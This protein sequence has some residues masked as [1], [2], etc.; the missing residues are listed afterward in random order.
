MRRTQMGGKGSNIITRMKLNCVEDGESLEKI[1][2]IINSSRK[3]FE[4]MHD[5][6]EECQN[7]IN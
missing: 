1:A 5:S 2:L 7:A 3:G 4:R 6:L